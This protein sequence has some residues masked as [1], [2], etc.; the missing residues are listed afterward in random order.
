MS[1]GLINIE[2]VF[3]DGKSTNKVNVIYTNKTHESKVD[4]DDEDE[5]ED[6]VLMDLTVTAGVGPD[7]FVVDGDS[8]DSVD[9]YTK[10]GDEEDTKGFYLKPED[11]I[12]TDGLYNNENELNDVI[13]CHE[14]NS[15]I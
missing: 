7:E 11:E 9:D 14:G 8:A 12:K 6:I 5:D 2:Q 1:T 4:D 15:I 13:V 3:D 10:R